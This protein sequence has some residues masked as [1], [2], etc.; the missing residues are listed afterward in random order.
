M[1]KLNKE[2]LQKIYQSLSFA[3]NAGYRSARTDLKKKLKKD[4]LKFSEQE[5]SELHFA[6]KQGLFSFSYNET[7]KAL[8]RAFERD[9]FEVAGIM[10]YELEEKLKALASEIQKLPE[11]NISDRLELF[12]VKSAKI[13]AK[14]VPES[15]DGVPPAGV[16]KTNLQ[17]AVNSAHSAAQY[18]QF[19]DPDVRQVYPALQYKTQGDDHVRLEHA[20]LEGFTAYSYDAVWQEIYPPNGWNC[21]CEVLPMTKDEIKGMNLPKERN[22]AEINRIVTEG[23]IEKDFQ[24]NP[25]TDKTLFGKWKR[26]AM[27]DLPEDIRGEIKKMEREMLGK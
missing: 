27:N 1:N 18:N 24:G 11:S 16:L 2:R 21:R 15:V 4:I 6:D 19:I 20:K 8:L 13:I 7:D 17:T 10:T 26:Q 23:G 5:L 9:C 25:A 12:A 3:M 14:Y 22:Q